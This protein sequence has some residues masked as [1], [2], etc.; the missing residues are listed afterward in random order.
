[1]CRQRL[2]VIIIADFISQTELV[3][4]QEHRHYKIRLLKYLVAVDHQRMIIQQERV[5]ISRRVLEIPF[6]LRQE[7]IILCVD[8][9]FLVKRN[10]HLAGS[11]L[12]ALCFFNGKPYCLPEPLIIIRILLLQQPGGLV[13]I[14]EL[15]LDHQIGVGIIIHNSRI[16]IRPRYSID[17]EGSA[18]YRIEMAQIRPKTRGFK[19]NLRPF[20]DQKIEVPRRLHILLEP[21]C[22]ISINMCLGS[23]RRE[24]GRVL[25]A[26]YRAPGIQCPLLRHHCGPFPCLAECGI[27]EIQ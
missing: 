1:M 11:F 10:K 4:K 17:T 13:G 16:F 15:V 24:V 9:Q 20:T 8:A 7:R 5:F 26:V 2:V 25:F 3:S 21:I 14:E 22:D 19:E 27:A 23:T 6:P 12:P 18:A